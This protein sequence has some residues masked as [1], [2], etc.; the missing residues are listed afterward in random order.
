MASMAFCSHDIRQIS[1]PVSGQ[2]HLPVN[3]K[4][5]GGKPQSAV[6]QLR[7]LKGGFAGQNTLAMIGALL[8]H[9]NTRATARYG[10][11]ANDVK[12]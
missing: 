8:G 12:G 6:T 5:L 3:W 9:A 10:H 11:L 4:L 1:A 7:T 2:P